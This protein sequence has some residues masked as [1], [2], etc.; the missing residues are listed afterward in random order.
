MKVLVNGTPLLAPLTG[1]GQYIRHLFT[2]MDRLALVDLCTVYGIRIEDGF[3]LPAATSAH[4]A[5]RLNRLLQRWM[6]FPRATRHVLQQALF[7][8]RSK[9][10]LKGAIYHE[11]N[12][13]PMP[14]DGPLV[15]TIC[16]MSCFDHPE[17]HPVERVHVMEKRLPAAIERA[18][19]ILVISEDSKHALQRWF[20]V[21]D[22][23]I[24]VTYL[25]ADAR[26][27]PRDNA[28]L[29][30]VLSELGLDPQGY[31]LC[32]G[33]LEPRKNLQTL[34][35]AYAGMPP[36]LRQ[37]F[38]LVVAGMSG[39]NTGAL[40]KDA[41]NLIHQGQLRL[42]GYVKDEQI[43][44]LYAGAAA[45]CYPS[46][47][48]GFGLPALE[49]MASGVPVVVANRT[50]LPE[51]VGPAGMMVDPDDV[52]AMR[53]SLLTLLEDG[54][55][56]SRLANLGLQRAATFSWERCARETVQVYEHIAQVRGL[57]G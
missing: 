39:W 5:Q 38:P 52:D 32:V 28:Q 3:Q 44:S 55:V 15:L 41:Q 30:P 23:K 12:Y 31:L 35:T 46:R 18:D 25:A 36:A 14:F 10:G 2:A 16:D 19:H 6:P 9:A 22:D 56:A 50:S 33:T 8:Y 17:T 53:E 37:R 1:I 49:A 29:Q 21:P 54:S 51:V 24:T 48:E 4:T 27:R 11:P 13:L 34:F 42:L 57:E 45:F 20:D 47:Y 26:F 40:M 43:P 7:R